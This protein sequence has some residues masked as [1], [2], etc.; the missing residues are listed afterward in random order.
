MRRKQQAI[1]VCVCVCAFVT[2]RVGA[3]SAAAASGSFRE[4]AKAVGG[5]VGISSH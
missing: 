5:S 3:K 4:A 1:C 2:E